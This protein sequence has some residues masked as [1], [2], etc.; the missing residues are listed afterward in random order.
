[1]INKIFLWICASVCLME[2]NS[3]HFSKKKMEIFYAS[4]DS[5]ECFRNSSCSYAPQIWLWFQIPGWNRIE[6]A[7][8]NVNMSSRFTITIISAYIPPGNTLREED[9]DAFLGTN[10]KI[11]VGS[12]RKS[13]IIN[14]KVW[15]LFRHFDMLRYAVTIPV[16]KMLPRCMMF[17]C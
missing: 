2:Q 8:V 17:T 4:V 16:F 9:F 3:K 12:R 14:A 15:V 10:K 1:M 5:L 13:R 11:I 6:S 7:V